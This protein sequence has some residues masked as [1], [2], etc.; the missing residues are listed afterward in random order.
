MGIVNEQVK[1][2]YL[3]R[4]Y[5]V[6]GIHSYVDALRWV[7]NII[8]LDGLLFQLDSVLITNAAGT[9]PNIRFDA[10]TFAAEFRHWHTPVCELL[11]AGM[12]A[13][14]ATITAN[15]EE[16][17]S[18]L[19]FG[20]D[21]MAQPPRSFITCMQGQKD[22]FP[23]LLQALCHDQTVDWKTCYESKPIHVSLVQ[24]CLEDDQYINTYHLSTMKDRMSAL[25]FASYLL[26]EN[27][28]HVAIQSI[29]VEVPLDDECHLPLRIAPM[30]IQKKG[31]ALM[32]LSPYTSI[33]RA[34]SITGTYRGLPAQYGIDF[35][36]P[37]SGVMPTLNIY[38]HP[39][40]TNTVLCDLECWLRNIGQK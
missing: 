20:M 40:E 4:E 25:Q 17:G 23:K 18:L 22:A 33:I 16:S 1:N 11:P 7:D 8:Q 3:T 36:A 21:L 27:P 30:S 29:H 19:T 9:G 39:E 6:G 10:D 2:G 5:T 34:L 13:S 37:G 31:S 35:G 15:S 24:S 38:S 28:L 14:K 26:E 12:M 32:Q